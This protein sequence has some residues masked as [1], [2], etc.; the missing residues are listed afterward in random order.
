MLKATSRYF[1]KSAAQRAAGAAATSSSLTTSQNHTQSNLSAVM[2]GDKFA[3]VWVTNLQ[4]KVAAGDVIMV[5]RLR[6]EIGSTIALKK[7]LMVG[8]QR[9]T[10]V[11]RPLLDN[12]RVLCTLE[13]QN[14]GTTVASLSMPKTRQ[15]DWTFSNHKFSVLRV[16]SIE[17]EPNVV[18]EVDKYTG[19]LAS[20]AAEAQNLASSAAASGKYGLNGMHWDVQPPFVQT[21]PRPPQ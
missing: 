11:G 10:A 4:Y 20:T 3:V 6:A 7:V 9:F 15:F 16:T 17:Y 14:D 2:A 13:E 5:Q 8:G 19:D 21:A 18:G 1:A 12:A